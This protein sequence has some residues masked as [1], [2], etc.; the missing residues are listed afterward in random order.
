MSYELIENDLDDSAVDKRISFSDV[1]LLSRRRMI[2][3]WLRW[4]RSCAICQSSLP[5]IDFLCEDCWNHFDRIRNRGDWLAQPGYPFPV[6]SLLSWT[7]E[8]DAFVRPF[9]YGLKRGWAVAALEKLTQLLVFE[10]RWG[11][12]NSSPLFV[13]PESSNGKPDHSRLLGLVLGHQWGSSAFALEWEQEGPRSNR[14]SQKRLN[15]S[16]RAERRFAEVFSEVRYAEMTSTRVFVDDVITS[17][18]TAVAAHLALGHPERFEVWALVCRPKL[19]TLKR[20]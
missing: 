12:E 9:I 8:N 3:G 1:K 13:H 18:A 15:V 17:G 11:R 2:D 6:Y 16:G 5:P 10:R 7:D 14:M 20:F 19:A 4:F